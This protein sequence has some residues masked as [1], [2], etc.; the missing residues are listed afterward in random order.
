MGCNTGVSGRHAIGASIIRRIC[1]L[2][3]VQ[4]RMCRL[5]GREAEQLP[6]LASF[7][8]IKRVPDM[9]STE[10]RNAPAIQ[11]VT[12]TTPASFLDSF[13]GNARCHPA[14]NCPGR[15]HN[16][17]HHNLAP[18]SSVLCVLP[19]SHQVHSLKHPCP[20]DEL[21]RS[22][23]ATHLRRHLHDPRQLPR[24]HPP[25]PRRHPPRIR[26]LH[27]ARADCTHAGRPQEQFI[28]WRKARRDDRL[29]GAA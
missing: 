16:L 20:N 6:C 1:G 28:G 21:T 18:T 8:A 22:P 27:T 26:N 14:T 10:P 9:S 7:P 11:G 25:P 13:P 19:W 24:H 3:M 4:E 12:A 2:K 5:H 17:T 29:K 15:G 23:H